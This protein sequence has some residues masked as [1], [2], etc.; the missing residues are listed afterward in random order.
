MARPQYC[1]QHEAEDEDS[2]AE[3]NDAPVD[4][5][6]LPGSC[7]ARARG[8]NRGRPKTKPAKFRLA[9]A[10]MGEPG[11]KVSNLCTEPGITHQTLFRHVSPTGGLRPDGEK[12]L[13]KK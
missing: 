6:L 2:S 10:F 3:T 13:T 1:F 7:S 4:H 12:L 9:K 11:T 8:R 5:R